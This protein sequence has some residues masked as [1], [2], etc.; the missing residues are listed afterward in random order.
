L[1]PCILGDKKGNTCKKKKFVIDAIESTFV[2][3]VGAYVDLFEKQ[4]ASVA[5]TKYAVATVNGTSALHMCLLLDGV[6]SED[7]VITQALTFI[8]TSNAISYL[9]SK[10]IFIDIDEDSLGMSPTKLKSFLEKNAEKR[11]DGFTYNKSSQRIKSC[12]PMHTFGLP[13]RID[14]IVEICSD[15]NISV[16]ED[17]AESIGS[18]YKG[19]PTGSFGKMGAFSFNGNKIITSGGGGAIVT[20]HEDIAKLAKHLTTQAKIAHR[21][22]FKH[23]F[24][25]FNYRMPNLN[26][27]LLCAQ[28]E[29]LESFVKNKR[30]LA[31]I[32]KEKF[33]TIGIEFIQEI[34]NAKSN[35]WLNVIKLGDRKER[36]EFLE[37][38]NN[39]GVMTRPCWTLMNKL[40]MFSSCEHDGLEVSNNMEDRLV[41]IPSS[42]RL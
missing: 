8:A 1:T 29:C 36:D 42:V 11:A 40:P 39:S 5:G 20:N 37:F 15:W 6:I 24:I 23:N 14:E 18:Y 32:Y 38:S 3:S 31:S 41:N 22:E 4:M 12:V 33:E 34:E 35:Y 21:W 10:P 2:S 26:A 28:L 19:R 7:E 9:G 17:S 30:E 27:A 16:I 25:G 13:C